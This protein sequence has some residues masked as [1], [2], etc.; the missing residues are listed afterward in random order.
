PERSL[1]PERRLLAHTPAT[2]LPAF[3]FGAASLRILIGRSLGMVQPFRLYTHEKRKDRSADSAEDAS[4]LAVLAPL[5][6][7][8]SRT[9]I[10]RTQEGPPPWH[11]SPSSASVSSF[12]GTSPHTGCFAPTRSIAGSFATSSSATSINCR[13]ASS[14]RT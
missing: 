7:I 1:R 8:P 5:G 13:T 2:R 10:P 12:S 11:C 3:D 14:R 4:A 9:R 6:Y